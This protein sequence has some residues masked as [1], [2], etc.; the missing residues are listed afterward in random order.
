MAH[1]ESKVRLAFRGIMDRKVRQGHRDLGEP[2]TLTQTP[3]L[4]NIHNAPVEVS[5]AEPAVS[6]S[7]FCFK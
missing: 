6:F 3:V 7:K 2:E 1:R 4:G 5:Q